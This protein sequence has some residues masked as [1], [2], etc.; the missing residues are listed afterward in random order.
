MSTLLENGADPSAY[1]DTG[2]T[3]LHTACKRG[4]VD[5][6]QLLLQAGGN[7]SATDNS[8]ATP[9]HEAAT[10]GSKQIVL[11]LLKVTRASYCLEPQLV[12]QRCVFRLVAIL[13]QSEMTARLR[14][15]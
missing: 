15:T 4:D 9:L 14:W 8:F 2:V 10:A 6:A 13:S 7:A 3:P 12:F 1:D 11:A 5:S